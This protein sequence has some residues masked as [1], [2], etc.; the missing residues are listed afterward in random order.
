MTDWAT[1]MYDF[2]DFDD[3]DP[4]SLSFLPV[5][6]FGGDFYGNFLPLI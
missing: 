1:V 6:R 4:D 2:G 3:F 5:A